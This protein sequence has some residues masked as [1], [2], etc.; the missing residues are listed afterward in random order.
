[1]KRRNFLK[2]SMASAA[3]AVAAGAG[4]LKPT[5]VLAANWP[6]AALSADNVDAAMQAAFGTT[7]VTDSGDVQI[8]APLQAENGAVVPIQ[9]STTA[10]ADKIAIISEKNP[11]PMV[12]MLDAGEGAGG[13]FS[14]RIK[15][16]ET[17]PV[18]CIVSSGG[19]LLRATQEIKVTVGGCGG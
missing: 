12:T 5:R 3:L 13:L 14:V 17:S 10:N 2:G 11:V 7:D 8:K 6:E 19:K 9:V 4:L 16:G 15:M 18:H 1:M